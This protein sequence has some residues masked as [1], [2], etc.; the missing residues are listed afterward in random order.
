MDQNVNQE[1]IIRVA[2]GYLMLIVLPLVL[3]LTIWGLVLTIQA[4]W[5]LLSILL[6]V[7]V[8]VDWLGGGR[9]QAAEIFALNV[10]RENFIGL[11]DRLTVSTIGRELLR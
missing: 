7:A 10:E 3:G 2:S 6:G 9:L 5:V 11:S 8:L 4:E 1:N